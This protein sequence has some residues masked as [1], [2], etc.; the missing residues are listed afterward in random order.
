MRPQVLICS[1]LQEEL[2]RKLIDDVPEVD[3][4][5]RPD[6]LP[7]PQFGADHW[8]TPRD[9]SDRQIA[10]WQA[11]LGDATVMFDFDWWQPRAWQENSPNLA[12]IQ[13]T[14]AGVGARAEAMGHSSNRVRITTAAGVHAKPLAE[15]ALAG[16]L[17]FV[18]ELPRLGSQKESQR[19]ENGAS[20]TLHGQRALIVGAGSIGSEVART[21]SFMGVSCDGTTRGSRAL[22]Q[23]FEHSVSLRDCDL[24]AY[25]IVVLA[26][27]LTAETTGLL[28][29]QRISAMREGALLVNLARGPVIDQEALID[30]LK[31]GHLGGA[32]LDV[33]EPEPL[34]AGHSL[35]D[36][37]NLVLS[38][39]TA[40]NVDAENARLVE[41]FTK[42]LR[43]YLTGEKLLNSY[44]PFL[45]Y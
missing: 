29:K 37:P 40:A 28:N 16:L 18:R 30:S 43:R 35:W 38:P 10:E 11:H 34:P 6:L 3:V 23:P 1:Y 9:L 15:F 32:V 20:N 27:P 19:W 17:Y 21:L 33:A 25:H 31:T 13:A 26:C 2:V 45:G 36:A 22:E 5:Y 14:Q 4:V 8:G 44:D 41:L 7:V 24:G 12:W 42:N 39:H